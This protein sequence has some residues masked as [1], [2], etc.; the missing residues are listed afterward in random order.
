VVHQQRLEQSGGH[1][2]EVGYRIGGRRLFEIL[3]G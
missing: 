3:P 1:L 2:G